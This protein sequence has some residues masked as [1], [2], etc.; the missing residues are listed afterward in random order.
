LPD[1]PTSSLFFGVGFWGRGDGEGPW[2]LA[3]F[4]EG[5]WA[6]GSMVGDPGW[7]VLAEDSPPNTANPA[8]G[9]PFALGFLS[10]DD[11]GWAL[12]MANAET[13]TGLTSAYEGA[14][15]LELDNVGGVVLG[16]SGDNSN[17]S[18]GT[19]YEGAIVAGRPSAAVEQ[20]VLENIQGVGYW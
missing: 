13:A 1:E 12:E 5:I 15:P 3:H 18:W 2:F 17:N 19:F 16:V 7:G 6:G 9:V 10:T 14:L 20:A 4:Q 11:E 8:L